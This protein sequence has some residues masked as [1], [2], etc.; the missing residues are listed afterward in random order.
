MCRHLAIKGGFD[1]RL[2]LHAKFRRETVTR[3]E[4]LTGNKTFKGITAHEQGNPLAFLQMQDA[5]ADMIQIIKF[6][7]E[8]LVAREGFKDIDQCL[9]IVAGRREAGT[10]DGFGKLHAQKRNEARAEVIGNR[11]E[12]TDKEM[13]ADNLAFIIEL[14]DDNRVEMHRTMHG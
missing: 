1:H 2:E 3:T 9:G 14:L 8:K 11:G 7:L 12:Q 4:N 10:L 5:H 13:L 6:D